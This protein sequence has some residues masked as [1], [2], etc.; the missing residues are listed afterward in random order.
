MVSKGLF[1]IFSSLRSYVLLRCNHL[2]DYSATNIYRC[3]CARNYSDPLASWGWDSHK[4][5]YFYGY[6]AFLLATYE[7][8]TKTDLPLY[9]RL[10]EAKQHDSISALVCLS[11]F[12]SL[13]PTRKICYF[14]ADSACDNWATYSLLS[15]WNITP[16]I[17]IRK[18]NVGNKKYT[19]ITVD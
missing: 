18:N 6:S 17:P 9:F 14:L 1:S 11:E 2:Y 15:E 8:K 19:A 4:E 16:I 7:K 12:R 3:T 10:V 5:Q 13:D